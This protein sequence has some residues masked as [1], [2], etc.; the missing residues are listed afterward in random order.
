MA[1]ALSSRE[2]DEYV[3][4]IKTRNRSASMTSDSI[5]DRFYSDRIAT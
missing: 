1:M 5:L 4:R 3:E 2:R